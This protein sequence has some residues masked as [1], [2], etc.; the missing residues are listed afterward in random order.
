MPFSVLILIAVLIAIVRSQRDPGLVFVAL[1]ILAMFW[2]IIIGT[3]MLGV[4]VIVCAIQ[5]P[6]AFL[7]W[8]PLE[9]IANGL[10]A[11]RFAHQA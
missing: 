9:E 3:L 10:L 1:G 8:E 11:F 5:T 6:S 4:G 2:S 7:F